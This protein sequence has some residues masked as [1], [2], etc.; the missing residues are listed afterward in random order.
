MCVTN[1]AY[2]SPARSRS[3][4]ENPTDDVRFH[5]QHPPH[6]PPY[7]YYPPPY[8]HL[9]PY[10]PYPYHP[11]GF[12]SSPYCTDVAKEPKGSSWLG[13]VLLI[14]LLLCVISIVFYR[15]L[16]RDTRR[17]LNARL[18]TLVQPAQVNLAFGYCLILLY[19]YCRSSPLPLRR[20]DCFES[21]ETG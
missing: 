13:I 1:S 15:S 2:R 19:F 5:Q 4:N 7:I 9:N 17:R 18:P 3:P 11:G 20:C 16:S 12:Y 6:P 8:P 14:F 21:I 10:A